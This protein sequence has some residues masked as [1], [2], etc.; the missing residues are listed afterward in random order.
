MPENSLDIDEMFA[1]LGYRRKR[2][3]MYEKNIDGD[4]QHGID[5]DRVNRGGGVVVFSPYLYVYIKKVGEFIW[6]GLSEAIPDIK[7]AKVYKIS[8]SIVAQG[9]LIDIMSERG[10]GRD[11]G[12]YDSYS[13]S[14][15]SVVVERKIYDDFRLVEKDFFS[16]LDAPEKIIEH[17]MS[18]RTQL[19]HWLTITVALYYFYKTKREFIDLIDELSKEETNEAID[20]YIFYA[21]NK[22]EYKV[23]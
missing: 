2:M 19:F 10:Y 15:G 17:Q 23:S 9:L 6:K 3:R 5:L 14:G 13:S 1:R 8:D 4:I 20:R 16:N 22:L 21:R 7:R 12:D 11:I 18:R